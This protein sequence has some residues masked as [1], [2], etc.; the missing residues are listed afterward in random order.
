MRYRVIV[1]SGVLERPGFLDVA[2]EAGALGEEIRVLP[3]LPTRLFIADDAM[4]L[5]PMRSHGEDRSA[6]ALLVHPSGL[7]DLVIAIFEE[8]WKTATD[9]LLDDDGA[10]RDRRRPRSAEAAAARSHRRH[11]RRRSCGISVRTVQRRIAELMDDGGRHDPHPA[12]RRGR[13]PRL[14]LSRARQRLMPNRKYAAGPIQFTRM[15][16]IHTGFDHC[17]SR[18]SRC[19]RSQNA[20]NA[21]ATWTTPEHRQAD[22][23]R[24]ADCLL[25]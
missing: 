5:L 19:H 9:F 6:G 13:A 23:A 3:T 18:A 25:R 11:R 12:R 10:G 7:L 15:I 22:A 1:E 16:G 20:R 4:A 8:Y 17:T 2:R 21:N 24:D 14:G